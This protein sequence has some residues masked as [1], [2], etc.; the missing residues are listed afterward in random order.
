MPL[1]ACMSDPPPPCPSASILS[2]ASE[3]TRFLPNRGRDLTDVTFQAAIER[4]GTVCDYNRARDVVTSTTGVRL[5]VTRGSAA[6]SAETEVVFFVAVVDKEQNI[7]ARERFTSTFGFQANQRQAGAVEEIEQIIPIRDG[8]RGLDYEILVGF[9]LT[10]E[11]LEFNRQ[12]R[13][14]RTGLPR[15]PG[16]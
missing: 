9:E 5:L 11:Q 7:L 4:V 16:R 12:Q 6:Q 2:D 1:M 15:L 13:Q 3:L 14:R 8:L 10:P